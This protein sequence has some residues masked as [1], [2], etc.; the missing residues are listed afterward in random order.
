MI[1]YGMKTWSYESKI[2]EKIFNNVPR[3]VVE[4]TDKSG[5]AIVGSLSEFGKNNAFILNADGTDRL[6]LTIPHK[7][8]DAICFNE[9]Y[10]IMGELTAIIVAN[11]VDFA[12][13]VNSDTGEFN[14]INETR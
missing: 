5:F 14:K 12:C 11:G 4:L 2:K 13:T 3:S 10:Y 9:V 6:I 8:R 7:I 1:L